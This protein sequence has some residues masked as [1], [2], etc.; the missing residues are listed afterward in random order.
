[1]GLQIYNKLFLNNK[2]KKNYIFIFNGF[3]FIISVV[4]VVNCHQLK[5]NHINLGT[6][7]YKS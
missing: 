5:P 3:C 4:A 1:M 2:I 6:I 7:L